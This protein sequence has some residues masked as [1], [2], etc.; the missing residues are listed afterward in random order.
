MNNFRGCGR[1]HTFI[2]SKED[3]Q[4][5]ICQKWRHIALRCYHRFDIS[6]TGTAAST[7]PHQALVAE[8][9]SS[10]PSQK[11]FLDSDAI[12]HV[13]LDVNCL[14]SPQPYTGSDKVFIDNDSGLCI[15]HTVT[16]SLVTLDSSLQLK[17]VL[18]VPQLTKNLLS[19]SQLLQDNIVTVEFTSIYCFVKDQ[20]T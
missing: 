15:S 20:H 10:S 18:C 3:A 19:I 4:C 8:P 1:D 13:T 5:Q 14:L 9:T 12:A 6:Y 7:Q 17:N 2:Q 11:W 16:S